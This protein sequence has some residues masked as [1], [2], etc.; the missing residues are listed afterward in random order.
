ML[1]LIISPSSLSIAAAVLCG[2]H[3]HR[4]DR[5]HLILAILNESCARRAQTEQ[6][7]NYRCVCFG[8][9][10]ER[11]AR[12]VIPKVFTET[13][14]ILH[15]THRKVD[16]YVHYRWAHIARWAFVLGCWTNRIQNIFSMQ[17]SY[18]APIHGLIRITPVRCSSRIFALWK[19]RPNA[20]RYQWR[21]STHSGEWGRSSQNE[22][23]VNEFSF[24]SLPIDVSHIWRLCKVYYVSSSITQTSSVS[25]LWMGAKG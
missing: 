1:C 23:Q 5:A 10:C 11:N 17:Q 13:T 6:P 19:S 4:S 16:N 18:V 14:S 15:P 2:K 25:F 22:H 20:G 21:W 7:T 3:M 12:A 9:Y 24:K 8:S